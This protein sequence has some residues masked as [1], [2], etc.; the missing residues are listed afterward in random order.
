M[1]RGL[2]QATPPPRQPRPPRRGLSAAPRSARDAAGRAAGRRLG[3]GPPPLPGWFLWRAALSAAPP[4][5]PA[6]RGRLS[7]P[8]PLPRRTRPLGAVRSRAAAARSGAGPGWGLRRDLEQFCLRRVN[9]LPFLAAFLTP[10]RARRGFSLRLNKWGA[11][12]GAPE[13]RSPAS[14]RQLPTS[15]LPS[16]QQHPGPAR[17]SVALTL[18]IRLSHVS[19]RQVRRQLNL[20]IPS[21][22]EP[23]I[24][25]AQGQR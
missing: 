25:S 3:E 14:R 9:E 12:H 5:S 6:Q 13:Q 15:L 22:S 19:L 11:G 17:T 23:Q 21:S 24:G 16:P 7:S 8:P 4:R 20:I 18:L 2:R 10:R 1:G